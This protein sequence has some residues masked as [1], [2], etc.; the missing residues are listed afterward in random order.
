MRDGKTLVFVEERYR[1]SSRFGAPAETVDTRKQSK[2]RA[3]AEHCLQQQGGHSQSACRF[4]V[5]AIEGE[6]PRRIH[7]LQNA[8]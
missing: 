7:W 8:F 5:L 3:T 6:D 2:L 4:D 1:R